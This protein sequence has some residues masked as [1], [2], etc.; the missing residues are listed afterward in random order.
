[1]GLGNQLACASLVALFSIALVVTTEF[2]VGG[3]ASR[4]LVPPVS[5]QTTAPF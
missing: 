3:K 5:H 4:D 1:M 2:F